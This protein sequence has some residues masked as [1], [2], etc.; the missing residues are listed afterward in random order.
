MVDFFL[1][2]I[3]VLAVLISR[4]INLKGIPIFTD[5]A[6]YIRWAQIGLNDPA[7]RYISLTDGKQPLM[8]WA[9]YPFLKFF[10]DPLIA[11]RLVSV[12]GA[13]LA[14]IGI[15]FLAK[16]LFDRKAAVFSVILYIISPFSM[17]YDRLALMDSLLAMFG[18][19]CL[20]L[21]VLLIKKLKLDV[22]LILGITAGSALLT[23]SS[24]SFF[25]YLI[26]FS[27]IIADWKKKTRIKSLVKWSGLIIL[28]IFIAQ[29]IYNSL[30]LSPY[31]YIIELKNYSFIMTFGEFIKEPFKVLQP[32]LKGMLLMLTA[33]LTWPLTAVLIFSLI[34]A[35]IRKDRII[36]YLF[37]WF[38]V[39]FAA[40]AVF[41]NVLY[42]RFL[43][44][45]VMPL[46]VIA[47]AFLAGLASF[48]AKKAKF[49]YLLIPL[50]LIMPAVNSFLIIVNPL[51]A[52]LPDSDRKQLFNDWPSGYGVEEVISFARKAAGNQKI[53]LAT[54]GTFG[55]NPAVYEIYLKES[56]NITIKGFWPVD[57]GL[58]ELK[59][60]AKMMPT[61]LV[62]KESQKLS[63]AWTVKEIFKIKRGDSSNYLYFYQ[64]KTD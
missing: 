63:P 30:R 16:T 2:G 1:I 54:E 39:P 27:L 28:S 18:I 12:S 31:F 46:Y 33:Y 4:I 60:D 55:L 49:L 29:V 9:M 59:S 3:S 47:A 38:F 26:P 23:K 58:E 10:E 61:Y 20:Y 44:F 13:A 14:V 6:I 7:H 21:Q 17:V 5:E 25:L 22:A 36:I 32:N 8:T 64:V 40:L 37:L 24:A 53:T 45:M 43:L 56:K 41:A 51:A 35:I 50:V 11:G 42:P 57:S 48:A 15:Y 52:G 62:L 19:W 34:L